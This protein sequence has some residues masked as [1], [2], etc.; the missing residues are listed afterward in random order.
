MTANPQTAETSDRGRVPV[1]PPSTRL[2]SLDVMRGFDMFWIVGGTTFVLALVAAIGNGPVIDVVKHQTTHAPWAGLR[3]EDLIFPIFVFMSGAT[4]PFALTARL[5]RGQ[6]KRTLYWRLL[7]RMVLLVALGLSSDF[8]ELDFPNMRPLSVLG[9]IG[10]AYFLAGLIVLNRG[11]RGQLAW[12]GGILLG[13]WAALYYIPVPG[14]TAERFS[15][16][17]CLVS[18]IDYHL[19]PGRLYGGVFDPEGI[20][21]FFPAAAMALIG[22]AAGRLLQTQTQSP[23][24]NVLILLGCGL[25]S[26]GLGFLWNPWFPIIK[27]IWSSSFILAAGGWGLILLALF[28][29]VIDVWRLRWL[30]FVFIPIGMNAITIYVAKIYIDFDYT[31]GRIFGGLAHVADEPVGPI[32]AAFGVLA[33]EWAMLY[34]L[35]RKKIFLRV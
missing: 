14:I 35:Y 18:Y 4:M 19:L 5:E 7:R 32:I 15:P 17:G 10:V 27:A 6:R 13:Y 22:A 30:G 33:V 34:F 9:L 26:L 20:L 21:C 28:Y 12:A 31:A 23:Y 1:P 11:V 25:A 16:G 24:R 3:A 8:F 2:A 29:L